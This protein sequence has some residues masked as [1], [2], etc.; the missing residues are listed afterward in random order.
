MPE[1][2]GVPHPTTQTPFNTGYINFSQKG[3]AAMQK[4]QGLGTI[5]EEHTNRGDPASSL[6]RFFLLL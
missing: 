1:D 5:L 6:S 4:P 3:I 2:T